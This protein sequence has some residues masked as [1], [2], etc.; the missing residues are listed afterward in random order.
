MSHSEGSLN[1]VFAWAYTHPCSTVEHVGV[2]ANTSDRDGLNER[3]DEVRECILEGGR[4]RELGD[5]VHHRNETN[6]WNRDFMKRTQ[7]EKTG[8]S[9]LKYCE[10]CATCMFRDRHVCDVDFP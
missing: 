5:K 7:K 2:R 1:K 9:A 6:S 3:A 10:V 4:G 8:R